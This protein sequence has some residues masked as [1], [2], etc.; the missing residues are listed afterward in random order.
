MHH[1]TNAAH[2]EGG[3]CCRLDRVVT[4]QKH[5][6]HILKCTEVRVCVITSGSRCAFGCLYD[7]IMLF[8]GEGGEVA[9]ELGV[10]LEEEALEVVA[11]L[12]H[13]RVVFVEDLAVLKHLQRVHNKLRPPIVAATT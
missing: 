11:S 13:R 6:K 10:S 8:V 1:R 4:K 3:G 5:H 7:V 9:D 12:S 2:L